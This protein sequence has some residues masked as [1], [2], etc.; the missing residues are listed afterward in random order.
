MKRLAL[1]LILLCSVAASAADRD[2][3][4]FVHQV[5][6]N[7][8]PALLTQHHEF[9]RGANALGRPMRAGFSAHLQYAFRFP[10][11]SN[12][13][14]IFPTAYQGAG[15]SV[16]TF[17]N[18][19]EIGTPSALYVFQGARIARLGDRLSLDYEWNF[20]VSFGWHPYVR[21][22]G[23]TAGNPN[24]I[25]VGTPVNA[26]MNGSILLSW[27]PAPEWVVSAG[28]DVA[29]FSNG[30]TTFPNTG[31][32][33]VGLRVG[34]ARSFG[35]I[36]R[37]PKTAAVVPFPE[38][39]RFADRIVYDLVIYGAWNEESV[40]YMDD[41]Y[42]ADGKFGVIGLSFNP[43]YQVSGCFSVGPSLDIQ[44]NENMNIQNHIAGINRSE[45]E[46][47]FYRPPLSEQLAAGV[48]LRAELTMPVFSINFG[49]GHN[50]IY[51]GKEL[52]GLY[53]TLALK[54][55]ITRSLFLHVGLKVSY[56]DVS[57][58][59]MLG[60]GWRFGQKSLIIK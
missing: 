55:F 30:D 47:R 18:H 16:N 26:Y 53:N 3:A 8:R 60:V 40:E 14:K 50:V 36:Y 10:S 23:E 48:S 38:D 34:A 37:N 19:K 52:G 11:S 54:T 25:V 59:L 33:T 4:A 29:H 51:K 15:V 41:E 49:I 58:N 28:L 39:S 31:V 57:N 56:T 13:G 20:G 17:F 12:F 22:T 27:Y 21:P 9:F 44:Y 1:I 7:V 6:M 35:G 45:D 42:V 46:I 24:N 43:L 5:G 2:S 32:N